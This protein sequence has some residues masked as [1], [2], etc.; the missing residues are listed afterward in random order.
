MATRKETQVPSTENIS[1]AG[2][3]DCPQAVHQKPHKNAPSV[4]TD[5]EIRFKPK[6]LGRS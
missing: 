4:I 6:V 2:D 5:L 3:S 1:C